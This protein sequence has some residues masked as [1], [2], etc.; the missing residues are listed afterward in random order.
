MSIFK[1]TINPEIAAQLKAREKVVSSP[2]RG[3]D[4]LRYT[5]GKNSWVR[6]ASFVNYDPKDGKYKGD[7]LSRKYILEGGTLY[8][9]SGNNFSLRSGVGK[10][11]GVYAS[12]L[13]KI[14]SNPADTK[15]DRMYGLRPMPGITSVN[16]MNKSAYGS[17]R[18]A[19]I[20]FYA[21][22]KHQLEELELLF[23]RTG[24]TVFLEWGWSQYIDHDAQGS[25]GINTEPDN[26]KVKNFDAK[27]IDIFST[28][29]NE[30]IIYYAIDD[31]VSKAKGNY[32]AMLGFIKNFSW[33]LMPNGG[34]Q[35]S[36]TIVSRGEAIETI[37]AS[38]NPYTI[39]GSA[40]DPAIASG[41]EQPQP[42]YSVFEKIF[43]N[44]IA[45]LNEAEFTNGFKLE[46]TKAGVLGQFYVSGSTAAQMKSLQD[47]AEKVYNDVDSE[48]MSTKFKGIKDDGSISDTWDIGSLDNSTFVRF[49]E[50]SEEGSAIEY[51]NIDA[52]IAILNKFFIFK[53]KNRKDSK[54]NPSPVISIVL[55]NNTPCLASEDSVSIDPTTCLIKNTKATL[56]CDNTEGFTYRISNRADFLATVAD[57]VTIYSSDIPEFIIQG[58]N[59]GAIGN[60]YLSINHIITKYRQLSGSSNG[61]DVVALL[62]NILDDVSFALG[63][64][65][66]FKLYNNRNIVQI[67]DVKYLGDGKKNSK[68]NFDLI[69]L[70]SI[71][72]DVKINSRVFAEQATMMA[73]GATSANHNTNLGDIYSSTQNFFNSGLSDRILTTVF[74]PKDPINM[75]GTA[76]DGTEVKGP[77]MLY[78]TLFNQ[79][80]ALSTYLRRN[81]MGDKTLTWQLFKVPSESDVINAGSLLKTLHYQINGKDVNFKA[82]I[83]FELEITLDGIGGFI[84]GQIFTVDKSILP[85]DYYNKNLGFIITGISHALQNNDWTTVIKTQIC[86][87]ENDDIPAK[88]VYGVD[89]TKLKGILS[90][91]K[92]AAYGSGYLLCAL[93]DFMVHQFFVYFICGRLQDPD[94]TRQNLLDI[95]DTEKVYDDLSYSYFLANQADDKDWLKLA[96][97]ATARPP[98]IEIPVGFQHYIPSTL[99]HDPYNYAR[100]GFSTIITVDKIDEYLRNWHGIQKNLQAADPFFPQDYNVFLAGNGTATFSAANFKK[101]L[102]GGADYDKAF[103]ASTQSDPAVLSDAWSKFWIAR[104]APNGYSIKT[105]SKADQTGPGI[106]TGKEDEHNIPFI[107]QSVP[108]SA[109]YPYLWD[110][111]KNQYQNK[112]PGQ[113]AQIAVDNWKTTQIYTPTSTGPV[114]IPSTYTYTYTGLQSGTFTDP[115]LRFF[116]FL[117]DNRDAFGVN[118][119]LNIP[120]DLT[121]HPEKYQLENVK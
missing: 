61:V 99:V 83:P 76:P 113:P 73:I 64:I 7:Q 49:C 84:V 48:L 71:C 119:M 36:T 27:T 97:T 33:Q 90:N 60:I 5:S 42:I 68:F 108:T 51:I 85:K 16:V 9:T 115:Y 28:K 80:V 44:I 78:V 63:G 52:F 65:N 4:F 39:L 6:M 100:R 57:K 31:S 118:K 116:K 32:D 74:E 94:D 12:N 47:A 18:E 35:C 38:A 58:T 1:S 75:V 55:A 41:L 70:K 17:L 2:N 86:L 46:S 79:I 69:G 72:R 111:L 77:Q 105:T 11:D 62:Q 26:I 37:K 21:W 22:D 107:V 54:G 15:V 23:M 20:N 59:I 3:D 34:F 87:L 96:G 56:V 93:S 8:N 101:L 66:D 109:D 82:I 95:R 112:T 102:E 98:K 45:H 88:S 92:T 110:G 103:T 19:T 67:I 14:S 40:P 13:D 10:L 114:S 50:G 120:G 25:K 29:L 121:A 117:F 43:L 24:Y 30:D 53:D 81:V 89:R 91:V 106:S 104:C